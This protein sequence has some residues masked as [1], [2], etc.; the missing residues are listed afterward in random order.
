[1]SAR[2]L[3]RGLAATTALFCALVGALFI[4]AFLDRALFPVLARPL[5]A[6]DAWGHF[7]LGFTGVTLVVW[8]GCLV[9][10]ARAPEEHRAVGTATA[11]GL[12]LAAVLR[13]LAWYSG[14]YRQAGDELRLEAA[15]FVVVALAFIWLRPA[16]AGA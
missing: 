3:Y 14:E 5:F 1:M 16:R 13:L 12:I 10:V 4:V 8:A 2:A 9:G 6:T 7:V 15:V 11:A